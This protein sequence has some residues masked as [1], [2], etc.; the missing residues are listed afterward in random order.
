MKKLALYMFMCVSVLS[1]IIIG[2][3]FIGQL[4]PIMKGI[5]FFCFVVC[6]FFKL[7]E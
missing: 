3:T 5:V 7:L 1:N 4:V 2:M 6:W